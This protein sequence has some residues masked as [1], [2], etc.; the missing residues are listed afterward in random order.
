MTDHPEVGS[1][2]SS[3]AESRDAPARRSVLLAC[4]REFDEPV[5]LPDLAD[6]IAVRESDEALSDL[7]GERVKEIYLSLYH[8][9]VPALADAGFVEYDQE[10]DLVRLTADVELDPDDGPGSDR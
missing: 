9:H 3:D 5:S 6:E 4:L 1:A 8:R 2:R 10:A 7:S